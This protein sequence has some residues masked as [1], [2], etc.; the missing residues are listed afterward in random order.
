MDN[1]ENIAGATRVERKPQF[2]VTTA[3]SS[4]FPRSRRNRRRANM[5]ICNASA[6]LV[7]TRTPTERP[8]DDSNPD[9]RSTTQQVQGSVEEGMQTAMAYVR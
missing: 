4:M 3:D 1:G 7:A 9:R 5:S 6:R 2:Q 8:L